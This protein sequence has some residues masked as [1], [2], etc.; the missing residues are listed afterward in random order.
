MI[1]A[2]GWW[3]NQKYKIVNKPRINVFRA[4]VVDP[5]LIQNNEP[6]LVVGITGYAVDKGDTRSLDHPGMDRYVRF[7]YL[8][9]Q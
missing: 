8:E 3:L 5:S 9:I 1:D 4:I 7:P 2:A 6:R